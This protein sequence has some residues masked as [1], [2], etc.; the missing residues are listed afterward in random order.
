MAYGSLDLCDQG[1][2]ELIPEASHWVQLEEPA[3]VNG[4]LADFLR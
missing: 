1:R 4:L 2:L 3:R